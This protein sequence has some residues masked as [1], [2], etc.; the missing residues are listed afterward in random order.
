MLDGVKIRPAETMSPYFYG[1]QCSIF[2]NRRMVPS[3]LSFVQHPSCP[4]SFPLTSRLL[5]IIL[6]PIRLA[7]SNVRRLRG[8]NIQMPFKFNA[9][10]FNVF[11][12]GK[13]A[14]ARL[15][16]RDLLF[17]SAFVLYY[18]DCLHVSLCELLLLL[19]VASHARIFS[20]GSH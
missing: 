13:I 20:F 4:N 15:Y 7:F 10:T 18:E 12:S 9:K 1:S 3:V 5:R 16:R 2:S 14:V 11:V 19:T 17:L 8:C 6:A